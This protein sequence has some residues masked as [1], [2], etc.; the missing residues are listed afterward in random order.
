VLVV[1]LVLAAVVSMAT[2]VLLGGLMLPREQVVER[3]LRVRA[4]APEVWAL[5]A[6]PLGFPTWLQRVRS[7]DPLGSAPLRWREFGEE[8]G[9]TWEAQHLNAPHRFVASALD[10]DLARHPTREVC[11]EETDDGTLV[12]LREVAQLSNPVLR[13]VYR[14]WLRPEPGLVAYLGDLRRALGE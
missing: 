12:T 13:F 10:E 7:V 9:V 1:L 5:V 11:L 3:Q 8:G 14:Y 4:R 2:A 6:D